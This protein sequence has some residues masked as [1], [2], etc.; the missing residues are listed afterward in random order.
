MR[1]VSWWKHG[2]PEEICRH[3][4]QKY[5]VRGQQG[6]RV[7]QSRAG[8]KTTSIGLLILDDLSTP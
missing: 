6:C 8:H 3:P 5:E 1:M 4:P 7:N 2:I